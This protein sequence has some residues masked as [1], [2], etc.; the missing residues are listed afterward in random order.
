[1]LKGG[2]L[3]VGCVMGVIVIIVGFTVIFTVFVEI[4]RHQ[5]PFGNDKV[6]DWMMGTPQPVAR[7]L[8]DNG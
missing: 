2:K 8:Q 3:F 1:M 6:A 5:L 7:E 4:S